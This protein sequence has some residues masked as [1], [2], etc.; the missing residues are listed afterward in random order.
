MLKELLIGII[1]Y[2]LI[3][4]VEISIKDIYKEFYPDKS[5]KKKK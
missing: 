1:G 5:K 3:R 4:L 2:C